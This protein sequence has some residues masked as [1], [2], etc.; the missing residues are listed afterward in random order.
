LNEQLGLG[1]LES[2]IYPEAAYTEAAWAS[3]QSKSIQLI[4]KTKSVTNLVNPKMS[5]HL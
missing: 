2:C 5:K 3:E 4:C 1:V